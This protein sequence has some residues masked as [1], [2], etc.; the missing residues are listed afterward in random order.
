MI[1]R[2]PRSTLFPYTT[3]FRSYNFLVNKWYFDAAYSVLLVRPALAVAHWCRIFDTKVIDS[4]VDGSA[5]ITVEVSR[6]SGRFDNGIVD[7]LV[8]LVA[9]TCYAVGNRL[10]N[11]Q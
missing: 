2:P 8:N 5:K 7:G 1:R 9:D 6:G 11:V 3:L 4:V 10:R